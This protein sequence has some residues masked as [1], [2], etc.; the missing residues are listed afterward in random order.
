MVN[1]GLL[2]PR[3]ISTLLYIPGTD[4]PTSPPQ[5]QS[6]GIGLTNQ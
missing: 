3:F 2:G 5:T 4:R 6:G 1:V